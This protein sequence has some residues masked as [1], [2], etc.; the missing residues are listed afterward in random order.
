MAGQSGV[1]KSSLLNSIQPDLQLR[2][3]EV[4][5]YTLRGR[6]TTA[7]A[8]LIKLDVGGHVVDTPGV[9][10]FD[11]ATV[12]RN[13]IECHFVEFVD[14]VQDCKFPDCTHTHEI[15]CAIKAA[16]E[17]G[18]IHPDRYESYVRMFNEE[19]GFGRAEA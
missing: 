3:G 2:V 8:R 5:E 13:E 1:G 15:G 10:S 6:H 11:T 17:R 19:D 4:N 14:F 7:S 16:L 12:P 18:D 9:R